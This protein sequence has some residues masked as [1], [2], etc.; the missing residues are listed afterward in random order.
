MTAI[1][2][3]TVAYGQRPAYTT[4]TEFGILTYVSPFFPGMGFTGRTFHGVK[5]RENWQA[6]LNAGVEHYTEYWILP[7][8]VRTKY[9]LHPEAVH[10]VYVGVDVGY[11]FSWLNKRPDEEHDY[12]GGMII[13]PTVGLRLGKRHRGSFTLSLTYQYQDFG[14]E[15]RFANSTIRDDFTFH[16]M[17]LRFGVMF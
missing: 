11:G 5:F 16:R 8:S 9:M 1:L 17:A 2:A 14:R 3:V 10:S 6:G 15:R 4:Q 13:H 7:M 12:S